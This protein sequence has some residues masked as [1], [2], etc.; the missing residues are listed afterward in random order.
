MPTGDVQDAVCTI[1][2]LKIIAEERAHLLAAWNVDCSNMDWSSAREA[3][4]IVQVKDFAL[5]RNRP[6][7][8]ACYHQLRLD[9]PLPGINTL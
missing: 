6:A 9:F 2:F 1:G 4:S 8:F 7:F 3:L 5:D